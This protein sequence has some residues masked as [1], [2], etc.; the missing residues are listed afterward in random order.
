MSKKSPMFLEKEATIYCDV[1]DTLLM[2]GEYPYSPEKGRIPILD[3]YDG[4]TVFLTPHRRHVKLLKDK[5]ARGF[6]V[7]VWSAGGAAWAKAAVDALGL[8][9][10]VDVILAKPGTYVDDLK[11]QEFMGSHLYL[12]DYKEEK[13]E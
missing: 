11:C 10:H 7:V 3:P 6:G 8:A 4:G 5:S 9:D 12:Q 2:W 13:E 1:D